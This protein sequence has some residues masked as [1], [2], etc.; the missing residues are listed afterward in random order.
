VSDTEGA[1][2][3]ERQES[4][5]AH[6]EKNSTCRTREEIHD[7]SSMFLKAKYHPDGTFD[8]VKARLVAGGDQ[9]DKYSTATSPPALY[10]PVQYLRSWRRTSSDTW[11]WWT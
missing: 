7:P 2:A 11:L 9:K 3:N 8:M 6:T 5:E 1:G 4:V 10:R